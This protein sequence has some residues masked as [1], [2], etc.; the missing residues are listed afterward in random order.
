MHTACTAAAL[1]VLAAAAHIAV[2]SDT[3]DQL[4]QIMQ[5]VAKQ[6]E[7]LHYLLAAVV[8]KVR[9]SGENTRH[10]VSGRLPTPT[11]C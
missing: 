4:L 8:G 6:Q 10:E 2:P 9:I 7:G 5:A 11:S 1:K 3:V